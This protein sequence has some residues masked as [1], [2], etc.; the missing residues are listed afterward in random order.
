MRNSASCPRTAPRPQNDGD[1]EQDAGRLRH[2]RD[3]ATDRLRVSKT[4][5]PQ[6]AQKAQKQTGN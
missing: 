6:K 1:R 5:K 3:D 4:V 2:D